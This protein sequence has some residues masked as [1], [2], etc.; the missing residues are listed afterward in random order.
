MTTT[1][2]Y[3]C[4]PTLLPPMYTGSYPVLRRRAHTLH[5]TNAQLAACNTMRELQGLAKT[6]Y[7]QLARR[8]HPDLVGKQGAHHGGAGL[9][10]TFRMITKTYRWLMALP[11]RALIVTSL[12]SPCEVLEHEYE[13]T[14]VWG[15]HYEYH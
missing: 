11:E 5:I 14:G 12:P 1:A 3:V 6:H 13:D 9:G 8:Y 4:G 2:L 7:R 10:A 15:W